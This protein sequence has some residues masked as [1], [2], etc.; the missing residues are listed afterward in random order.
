MGVEGPTETNPGIP[1]AGPDGSAAQIL[2]DTAITVV[3]FRERAYATRTLTVRSVLASQGF[4]L[5]SHPL[6]TAE[7][8]Q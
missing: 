1:A 6:P 4:P 3:L 2:P 5:G 7:R 8:P